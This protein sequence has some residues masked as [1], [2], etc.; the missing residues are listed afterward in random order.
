MVANAIMF[1]T[2]ANATNVLN[3]ISADGIEYDKKDL[4]ILS[5]YYR[6]NINRYGVFD[7]SR[8]TTKMELEFSINDE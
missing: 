7:L 2:V 1:H 6:E 5:A 3:Q 4:S 8:K